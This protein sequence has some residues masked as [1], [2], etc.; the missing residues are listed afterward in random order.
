MTNNRI[1]EKYKA[2]NEACKKYP[3]IN[4]GRSM[5]SYEKEDIRGYAKDGFIEVFC[6]P[7]EKHSVKIKKA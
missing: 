6:L 7:S 1:I 2:L 3:R 5:P 4:L